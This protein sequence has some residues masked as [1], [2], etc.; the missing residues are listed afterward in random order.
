MRR[1]SQARRK[2]RELI[3]TYAFWFRQHYNLTPNDPRYL[4]L[5]PDEIEAEYW[6]YHFFANP[7]TDSSEDE[8]FDTEK[9]ATLMEQED[10]IDVISNGGEVK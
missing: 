8:D 7:T 6:A 5:T 4:A 9:L 2:G 3:G 1:K 10:W